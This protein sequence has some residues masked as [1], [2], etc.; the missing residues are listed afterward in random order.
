MSKKSYIS[1]F[2]GCGGLS[3]GFKNSEKWAG[4]FAIEKSI[5]AYKTLDYNLISNGH[6]S[7]IDWL[8]RRA[9]DIREVIK[10]YK[11]ELM[12]LRGRVDLVAGGPPCQGFS[13]A[14]RRQESDSRNLLVDSYFEFI[15]LVQPKVVFFEN[16]KGFTYRFNKNTIQ[17]RI[18]SDY[19]LNKLSQQTKTFCGYD[20]SFQLVN[21]SDYGIPQK[22]TRFIMVGLRKDL[23]QKNKVDI[24]FNQLYQNR[25]KFLNSKGL[26]VKVSL[27]TSISDLNKKDILSCADSNGFYSSRYKMATTNYQQYLRRN[28]VDDVP[29]S[30]RFANHKSETVEKFTY[31]LKNCHSG[32]NISD[33]VKKK[34]NLKKRNIVPLSPNEASPT[35]T[36]LPDDY[37]HYK[38]PRILTVREY[39]RIQSFDDCFK[40]KGK[41]TT[42]GMLRKTEVPR[43]TQVGNAIPP[44][45]AE[46]VAIELSKLL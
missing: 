7:W 6:Y 41:Y 45:F 3:L 35:L 46:A 24:F 16:V 44:L 38:E 30:H 26:S 10:N 14:G 36:T 9:L 22:R 33:E 17:G 28:I 23:K 29:D 2:A 12:A 39:A 27:K 43:Y 34:F 21:F 11:N 18:H 25:E 8:D 19:I 32:K 37:I 20:T 15:K 5:D 4:L 1:V 13:T 40:F 31:L 42:G